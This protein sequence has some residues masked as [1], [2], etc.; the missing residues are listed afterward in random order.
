MCAT[1]MFSQS[2][3]P[4]IMHMCMRL[5]RSID[6]RT[7]S[8]ATPTT[9]CTKKVLMHANELQ[10]SPRVMAEESSYAP[11]GPHP[12]RNFASSVV[13]RDKSQA[14]WPWLHNNFCSTL[15]LLLA[16]W[17]MIIYYTVAREKNP[18][19]Y[20]A[21]IINRKDTCSR[22]RKEQVQRQIFQNCSL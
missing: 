20:L 17:K 19:Q 10:M 1:L 4:H 5:R 21:F 18:C 8:N 11:Q 14:A 9:Q 3:K 7:N 12:H 16:G 22:F 13:F 2:G 15:F 6:C